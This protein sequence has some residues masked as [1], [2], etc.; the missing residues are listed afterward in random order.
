MSWSRELH[1]TNVTACQLKN[2]WYQ[3]RDTCPLLLSCRGPEY[4][5]NS[6]YVCSLGLH[7]C[8]IHN[9]WHVIL[10]LLNVVIGTAG[11]SYWR[12]PQELIEC[13]T[14]EERALKGALH[15]MSPVRKRYASLIPT[16]CLWCSVDYCC[17]CKRKLKV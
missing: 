5:N 16:D 2:A 3:S 15:R 11:V 8:I 4:Y 17:F 1:T 13:W 10:W 9:T 6:Y 14:L 7:V 12:V